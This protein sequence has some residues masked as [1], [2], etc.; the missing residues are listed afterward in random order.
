M[1]PA[2]S[3]VRAE[4]IELMASLTHKQRTSKRFEKALKNLIDLDTGTILADELPFEQKA[5]LR[6]WRRDFLLATSLPNAFVKRFA[7][8]TA[9]ALTVWAQARKENNF[10]LYAPYLEKIVTLSQ[11]KAEL[12]GYKDHPYDALLDTFEP[13][14]TIDE[15]SPLFSEIK[16]GIGSILAHIQETPQV[17]DS[18]LHGNF[19]ADKQLAFG[20]VL[21]EAMGYDLDKGRLDLSSHPFSM[22]IHPSDSRITTRIH[23]TS[24]FDSLSA[25]LHEGGHSLYEMGMLPEYYGSPLCEAVS[26]GIHESQSR[27]WET[28]IGQSKPFWKHFLPKLA[29]TFPELRGVPLHSFYQAIN[30]VEPTLIRVEADE[31]TY[32]LHV[33]LRFE[34]EKQ[35]IEGSLKVKDLSEAWNTLT[36][37]LLGIT[38]PTDTE[39][40]LQDIHW[41]L[42]AFGY[43]PTYAL[44]N[45]YAS[46]FFETFET[47]FPDWVSEVERGE[48]LFI[49]KWLQQNIHQHGRAY[50]AADL[51]KK[52]TEHALSPTPYLNYLNTKYRAIYST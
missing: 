46:Q 2:G 24:L 22:A 3:P 34:L 28:R 16:K 27:F 26:L 41:A 25:V 36:H 13:D 35:L 33:I 1:P 52:V 42:G 12:I 21:L 29:H 8:L 44:G 40:C 30:R 4:Q 45:L 47:T 48:L 20:K 15:L 23:A 51:V 9:E 38:P 6:E 19:S 37:N 10:G 32:S 17:D 5:S 18:C 39:G 14:T 11:K 31:V 7:R 43:F 50:R 49:R